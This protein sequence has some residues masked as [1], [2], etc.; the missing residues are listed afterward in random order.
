[1]RRLSVFS[2]LFLF[3]L[4]GTAASLGVAAEKHGGM[5]VYKAEV[6]GAAVVPPVT[7]TAKGEATFEPTMGGKELRYKLTVDGIENVTVAHI[8]VG[9]KGK[10]GPP[11]AGLF[12]GPKKEGMFT[13]T[14][15]EGTITDA[16]L[17]GPLA[18]KTVKDLIKGIRKGEFYVNVHSVKYPDGEIRGQIK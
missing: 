16:N 8:H 7:T 6:S 11:V 14:L 13:G 17:V 10:S 12:A 9:K 2:I 3:L 5:H 4:I 18:G 15:A 1:M